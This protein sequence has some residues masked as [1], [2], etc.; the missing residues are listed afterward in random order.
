M[1]D[2]MSARTIYLSRLIGL[3][4]IVVILSLVIRKKATLDSVNVLFNSPAMML[5]TG[6]IA[7]A[8]G[9]AMILAHSIWKGGALPVVV[10]IVGWLALIKGL[11]F[12]LLPSGVESETVLSWLRHPLYFYLFMAPPFLIGVYLAYEGFR[13][14]AHA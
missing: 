10:S 13:L 11:M 5:L 2:I 7:V 1:E 9:L 3:Y 14:R 6:I 8:G 12:L 4:W